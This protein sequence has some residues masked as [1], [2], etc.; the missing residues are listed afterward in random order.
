N[1]TVE[2]RYT[3]TL[4]RRL[5]GSF[6]INQNNVYK[7]TELFQALTD[8]RAGKCT[9]NAPGYAANYTSKG[10]NP[11]DVNNDPVI[12][13]QLLA[14]LNLNTTLTGTTGFTAVGTTNGAG[15]Y[16]TGAQHLRRS[17]TFQ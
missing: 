1:F 17:G 5:T 4:G 14:G 9:A 7:N 16:Q 6:D 12:L 2:A 10:L 3:G 15:I 8:A 13:D 11:C